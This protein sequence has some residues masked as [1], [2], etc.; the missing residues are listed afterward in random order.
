M[1]QP[2][3][4]APGRI[5]S[6]LQCKCPHCGKGD[7]FKTANPYKLK[8]TLKMYEHCPVCGTDFEPEV[9]FYFGT[10]Y[11]S[12]GLSVALTVASF[13][14]SLFVFG[15]S[16]KD[17]SLFYWLAANTVLL[18]V[19]QPIIMRLSRSIWLAIFIRYKSKPAV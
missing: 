3:S 8:A 18:I 4:Q 14:F 11:V 12:Y 6:T 1:K 17:N 5:W 10:G 7:M 2:E 13:L 9:G 15:F 19:A 16:V